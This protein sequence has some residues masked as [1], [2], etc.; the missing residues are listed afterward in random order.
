MSEAPE[1]TS[2]QLEQ[3]AAG[4]RVGVADVAALAALR[5][6]N[7]QILADY[8]PPRVAAEVH[9][10][11]ALRE[12]EVRRAAQRRRVVWFGLPTVAA[13]AVV[14]VALRPGAPDVVPPG[15][16]V[17]ED[18]SDASDTRIKG[19][20]PHLK[21]HRQRGDGAELLR[22][23]AR[24]RA[25]DVLQVSYVAA[26]AT[27]GVVVSLDGAGVATLHYPASPTGST[28]LQ[29]GGAIRLGRA[30]ELDAAPTFERFM[31][32]TANGPIDPPQVLAAAEALARQPDADSR[33]LGLPASWTQSSFLILKSKE[34]P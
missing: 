7:A 27:D 1:P 8:P 12:A 29:Q 6:S 10:R 9:R 23:P 15:S 2:L 24:A 17:V 20:A 26:G 22:A 30:Y 16:P 21:I 19:L 13:A 3:I 18:M 34:S 11:V 5:A 32:V 31:F 25:G 33:S 28:A 14:I 4:E